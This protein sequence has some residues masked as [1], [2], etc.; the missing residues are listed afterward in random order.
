MTLSDDWNDYCFFDTETRSLPG[1][2][3]PYDDVTECGAHRYMQSAKPIMLQY[4]IGDGP[5]TVVG[6]D[7]WNGDPMNGYLTPRDLPDDFRD[8]QA[9]ALR[10]GKWFV[11]HNAAFDRLAMNALHPGCIEPRMIIDS[12]V[13]CASSNLPLR[14]EDASRALGRSGKQPEGKRLIAKFCGANGAL[15]EDQQD[16]WQLFKSYGFI[17]VAELR[18]IMQATR[19]LPVREW[20]EYWA[21]EAIND[22]GMPIDVAFVEKAAQLAD[23]SRGYINKEIAQITGGAVTKVT[24]IAR[25]VNYVQEHSTLPQVEEF[26]TKSFDEDDETGEVTTKL[27]LDRPRIERILNYLNAEDAARGLTDEDWAILQVLDL[28]LYGGSAAIATFSKLLTQRVGSRVCGQ[29]V[30]NGAAQTGRFSSRGVQTHNMTRSSL[31]QKEELAM[32]LVMGFPDA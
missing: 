22:R 3:A 18:G 11:A 14:L 21:S 31:G 29:Y 7:N 2:P 20:E 23:V 6:K 1:T 5:V 4:A 10:G 24:Q 12:M 17:D 27:G 9:R 25:I 30:A 13:Q 26:M 8:F 16:D 19:P 15:P 32:E 28:R